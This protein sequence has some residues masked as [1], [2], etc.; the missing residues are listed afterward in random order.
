MNFLIL[1]TLLSALSFIHNGSAPC[2]LKTMVISFW[3]E[4]GVHILKK[5]GFLLTETGDAVSWTLRR[6]VSLHT[7]LSLLLYTIYVL[8]YGPRIFKTEALEM[9]MS[10]RGS[11]SVQPHNRMYE[12]QVRD[13]RVR[14]ESIHRAYSSRIVATK[15]HLDSKQTF[16]CPTTRPAACRWSD[17][18]TISD[19][20]SFFK[21]CALGT[22]SLIGDIA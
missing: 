14:Y 18:V 2:P 4:T 12:I 16:C 6:A 7:Y 21:K 15:G 10:L 1:T 22:N 9:R 5:S 13:A 19:R 8:P 11:L 20:F 3:D 17:T